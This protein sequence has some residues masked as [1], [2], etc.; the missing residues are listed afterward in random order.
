MIVVSKID[1]DHI[2]GSGSSSFSLS[3]GNAGFN[4]SGNF[5]KI[6][7]ISRTAFLRKY[8]LVD[9]N[10]VK[11][12]LARSRLMSVETKQERPLIAQPASYMF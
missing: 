8:G 4:A 5:R 12:S 9:V 1:S 11:T 10:S 3:L 6:L 2:P 7:Y